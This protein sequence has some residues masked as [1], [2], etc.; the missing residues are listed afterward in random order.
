MTWCRPVHQVLFIAAFLP[1][2][3]GLGPWY[4]TLLVPFALL[5]PYGINEGVIEQR[6]RSA[7]L[8]AAHR[9]SDVEHAYRESWR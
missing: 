6:E 1:L 2:I 4:F 8:H 7:A 3:L 9:L 5:V